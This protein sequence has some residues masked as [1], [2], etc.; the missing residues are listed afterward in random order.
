MNMRLCAFGKGMGRAAVSGVNFI[1]EFSA[2][3]R[4][5]Y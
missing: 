2:L 4:G 3:H 5:F 1:G